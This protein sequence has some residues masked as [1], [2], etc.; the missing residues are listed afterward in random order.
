V[1]FSSLVFAQEELPGVTFPV[2]EL[3]NCGS[4]AECEAY[5]DLPENMEACLNFAEAHNLIPLGVNDGSKNAGV[6]SNGWSWRLPRP[7]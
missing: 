7:G 3:G 5:C 1:I 4:R 2:A 6:R